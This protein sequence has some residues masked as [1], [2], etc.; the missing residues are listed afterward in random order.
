MEL[1]IRIEREQRHWSRAR[2]ARELGTSE[3]S[4][5]QW[6]EGQAQP[7]PLF[8]QALVILFEQPEADIDAGLTGSKQHELTFLLQ[9][10][11]TETQEIQIDTHLQ[12]IEKR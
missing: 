8:Q 6:E 11:H 9:P 12:D 4:I 3:Q 5:V 1:N 2:L 10:E 7:S